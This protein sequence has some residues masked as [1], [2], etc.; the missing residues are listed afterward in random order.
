MIDEIH[1][2]GDRQT[3][4]CGVFGVFI[5]EE[6]D[7][8][9]SSIG[10]LSYY[11]LYALQHRGQESAGLAVCDGTEFSHH[12]G[13]GLVAEVFSDTFLDSLSGYAAIG[14]V[15]YST[16]GSSTIAN[17][18]PLLAQSRLGEIAITHNG[19]LVNAPVIR[20]LLE[21]TGVM[22]QT[23]SDSEVILSLVA[24]GARHGLERAVLDA[25]RAIQ[26]AFSLVFLTRDALIAVRDPKGIR[27]LV[28]GKLGTASI[29]ASESCS[30]D[31]I[32]AERIRDVRPGEILIIRR[33]GIQ[34]IMQHEQTENR[35]CSFEFVYFSRPDSEVDGL[36]VYASRMEAGRI[37]HRESP[38][39]ADV[40]S[41][42]P[43]SGVVAAHGFAEAAGLPFAMTL[44]K[45]KYVGR[46]FI[47]PTQ[48]LRERAV[49]VKLN[50]LR[51]NVTG[52]RIVLID[53]SI[54][55]GTT[56]RRLV[57]MLRRAGAREVHIRIASPP[58]RYPCYF[59]MDYPSREELAGRRSVEEV[60][61]EI[62]ADSLAYLSLPG[63]QQSLGGTGHFCFGC[64][65]GVYPVAAPLEQEKGALETPSSEPAATVT[66]GVLSVESPRKSSVHDASEA[67]SEQSLF[68]SLEPRTEEDV[69][70]GGRGVFVE[71][72]T[73]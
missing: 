34:S 9:R 7:Q 56:M 39:E 58:V 14:H 23:S 42:V 48:E 46:S 26:G 68:D 51:A 18:Q 19:N 45:N 13:M 54:V 28:L 73:R 43:D 36:S 25:M 52:K 41:G 24:R 22:F 29:V 6:N 10:R 61:E 37:L 59:G 15:R 71:D 40:V 53:D 62:G 1:D 3:E 30:L 69:R 49:S 67:P 63:L 11:G 21:D 60:R 72:R 35:V 4:E 64:L 20:D 38:V 8:L 32:G 17:A 50:V 55:R 5:P 27:P 12:R 2:Q 57:S 70:T 16:A 33:D 44:I 65:T 31:A 66:G 47:A